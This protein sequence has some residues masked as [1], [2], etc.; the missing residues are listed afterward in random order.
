MKKTIILAS[1]AVAAI[2]VFSSC[3]KEDLENTSVSGVRIITAEFENTATKTTLSTEDNVTPLW[4]EDDVIRVFGTRASGNQYDEITLTSG[5]ITNDGRTITFTTELTGTLYAVYP[6]T[7]TTMASCSDGK[8]TFTIPAV[9]DGTFA[10]A[11][12]CVARSSTDD[13]TNKDK[14][15]FSNATSVLEFSQTAATTKVLGVR[16]EAA[17]AI[18]GSMTVNYKADGTFDTPTT[19]SLTGKLINVKSKTAE[20]KY[21][22][23]VAPVTTGKIEFEYQKA[24]EVATVTTDA[25]KT[26]SANTIYACP[27]MD[28]QTYVIKSGSINGKDY[29]Q[30]GSVKWATMNLG[31]TTVADNKKTCYGDYFAWGETSEHS[32]KSDISFSNPIENAFADGH[33]FETAPAIG[34][35]AT[36]PLDKDAA[37]SIWGLNWRMPTSAE[38]QALYEACGKTGEYCTPSSGGTSTTTA[39]GIYW[40]SNYK[41]VEGLLFIVKD[42]GACLFFPA[43]GFGINTGLSLAGSSGY[44]WSSSRDPSDTDFAYSLDFDSGYV[45]PQSYNYRYHGLSVRPVSD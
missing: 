25:G 36:L 4:K 38:F 11:N 37:H 22:I 35:P 43:A 26:L 13:E 29:V 6:A 9:Q 44:Y 27:S 19:S 15:V 16:V 39:K 41:G 14:L 33:S 2:F 21:Y 1:V 18:A 5:Q 8:I 42:N 28:E 20:D 31:A 32:L 12:I 17:S 10:S 40:C 24:V 30:V 23:A 3:Q 45:G 7:A 34:D